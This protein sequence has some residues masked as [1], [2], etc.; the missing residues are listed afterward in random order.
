MSLVEG[1]EYGVFAGEFGGHEDVVVRNGEVDED[2][3]GGQEGTLRTRLAVVLVL[4]DRVVDGL[5][6]VGLEF[7]RDDGDAV[8]AQDNVDGFVG[9]GVEADLTH[10]AQAHGVRGFGDLDQL[11]VRGREFHHGAEL[12]DGATDLGISEAGAQDAEE[13]AHRFSGCVDAG[14]LAQF[15]RQMG[16]EAVLGFVSLADRE[17]RGDRFL[18]FVRVLGGQ[19]VEHIA[20]DKGEAHVPACGIGIPFILVEPAALT[21]FGANIRL[22]F[23]FEDLCVAHEATFFRPVTTSVMR[24]VRRSTRRILS[25]SIV[26]SMASILP[27]TSSRWSAMRRCL[28]V[29]W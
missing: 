11:G 8:D 12:G 13:A 7:H 29:P 28:S 16:E 25:S 4:A 15:L 2:A 27:V 17:A 18:V 23:E 19:P 26:A 10:D 9:G 14:R 3:P 22:K 5:G 24:A 21:Q 20:G 1:Q 6:V